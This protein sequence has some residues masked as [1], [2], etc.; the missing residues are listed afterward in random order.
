M[1]VSRAKRGQ[2][3]LPPSFGLPGSIFGK[4]N[5]GCFARETVCREEEVS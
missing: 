2:G 3:A 4:M 5:E 1:S